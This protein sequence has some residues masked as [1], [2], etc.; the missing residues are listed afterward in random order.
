MTDGRRRY[1]PSRLQ[2][3]SAC[4]YAYYLEKVRRAPQRQAVWFIQGTSVH[5][6]I[7]VYERSFR[8][9]DIS[10][11][12]EVFVTAWD[13]ELAAAQDK[14][15]DEEMWMVGGRK[16]VATD[17]QNRYE[18]G[19]QQVLDY[20]E[21]HTPEDDLQPAELVPGEPAVEVGFELNFGDFV[22]LGYIDC[23]LESRSTGALMPLDWKTGSKMPVDPYQLATYGMAIAELTGEAVEWAAYWDCLNNKLI[24]KDL[25]SYPKELV[26]GWYGQMHNGIQSGSFLPNP[27]GCFTC[28]V[29]PSCIFAA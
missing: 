29:K 8:T 11:A 12:K 16:K 21:R 27:G 28:T 13:R 4:S 25:K 10:K 22:V 20:I 23:I 15:P 19:T 18:V 9:L 26:G 17:I 2:T 5:E 3:Y 1:S 24:R 6:A 7:E 14:Q